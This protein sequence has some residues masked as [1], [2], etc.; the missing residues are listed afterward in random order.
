MVKSRNS[1]KPVVSVAVPIKDPSSGNVL[2][3]MALIVD[4]STQAKRVSGFKVGET[5]YAWMVNEAGFF[6]SHPN[7]DNILKENVK[8]L[9]GMEEVSKKMLAGRTP[10][11]S[12]TCT[13]ACQDLWLRPGQGQRLVR[14]LHPER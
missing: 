9:T 8:N 4:T 11:W 3:V 6:V 2:G 7:P 14:G 1:G 13:R 10:G 12:N 5:G